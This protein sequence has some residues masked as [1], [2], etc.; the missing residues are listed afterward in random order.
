MKARGAWY[1]PTLSL[2]EAT[3]VYADDPPWTHTAFFK[4]GLSPA[5]RA[6]LESN[7]WRAKT[8]AA[9]DS[10][11]ARKSL[12]MNLRNL[13]T[14]YDAGVKIGFGTDSGA[15]PLR[16]PGIAEHRELALMV[17][18]GLT[19]LQA[20]TVATSKA[21]ELLQRTDRGTLM[22]GKWADLVVLDA[23]PSVDI[24]ATNRIAAVWHR[25]RHINAGE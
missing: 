8:R 22:E 4:E 17:R 11:A 1:I 6:Q 14:L 24:A 21:A 9:P 23:D 19:P 12:D 16:I 7:D 2:D 5:L 3:F 20:I 18:A 15:S 25:G 13:K 10:A